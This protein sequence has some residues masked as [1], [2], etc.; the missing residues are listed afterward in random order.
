[1]LY[2][3]LG[4]GIVVVEAGRVGVKEFLLLVFVGAFDA[5]VSGWV[6]YVFIGD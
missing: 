4:G 5:D 6:L 3:A 1:M 2:G